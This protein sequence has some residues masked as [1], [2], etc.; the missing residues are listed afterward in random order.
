MSRYVV[1]GYGSGYVTVTDQAG[2]YGLRYV[3]GGLLKTPVTV[4]QTLRTYS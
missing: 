4:T 1:T 2:G 3:T